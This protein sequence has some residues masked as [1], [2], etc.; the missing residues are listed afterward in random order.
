[1]ATTSLTV[2]GYN[3][4]TDVSVTIS[5]QYG[6]T[7]NA[8]SLGH[9]RSIEA[10]WDM[11]N[12]KIQP[13][14][15]GGKPLYLSIPS[16]MT[17]NMHFTRFNGA[18]S[19]IFVELYQAFYSAGLLPKWTISCQVLNRDGTTDQ[20]IFTGVVFGRPQW[21][22]F[23]DI[24]EVDQ[25]FEFNAENVISTSTLQGIVPALAAAII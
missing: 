18:L 16:G 5:D 2:N 3:I 19:S 14:T 6:D 1:M 11:E 13:I 17:G 4:G 9:L 12:Q 20:Y 24:R 10:T 7:F 8:G 22:N 23:A 25:T 15:R 21:G